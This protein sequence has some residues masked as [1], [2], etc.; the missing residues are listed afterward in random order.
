MIDVHGFFVIVC[1]CTPCF[2]A[3]DLESR[4]ITLTFRETR[5]FRKSVRVCPKISK[6]KNT[7]P[8]YLHFAQE[9]PQMSTHAWSSNICLT[10]PITVI[11]PLSYWSCTK[12]QLMDSKVDSTSQL[13]PPD[14]CLEKKKHQQI[15][16]LSHSFTVVRIQSSVINHGCRGSFGIAS[17]T[18]FLL[19]FH[20]LQQSPCTS[21]AWIIARQT[22]LDTTG[23]VS[24][25]GRYTSVWLRHTN[26]TRWLDTYSFNGK[27]VYR[28]FSFR[29]WLLQ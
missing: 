21:K 26:K 14:F 2:H 27:C 16:D 8:D 25:S 24:C 15:S 19:A 6:Q 5:P 4:R 1:M 28:F 11:K 17:A 3:V 22:S 29:P 7:R 18:G 13:L 10:F 23:P 9:N 12:K 20:K